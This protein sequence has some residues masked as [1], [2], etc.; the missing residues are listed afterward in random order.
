MQFQNVQELNESKLNRPQTNWLPDRST[1][2]QGVASL[3][4]VIFLGLLFYIIEIRFIYLA[5][6]AVPLVFYFLVKL[7]IDQYWLTAAI[8]I[9]VDF[10]EDVIDELWD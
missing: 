2:S 3:M 7:F 1:I 6:L 9:E 8:D 4:L 10:L 5:F